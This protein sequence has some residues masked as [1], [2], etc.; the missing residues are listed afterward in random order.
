MKEVR[1]MPNMAIFRMAPLT[2][3]SRGKGSLGKA[4]KHLD[5][6]DRAAEISR[7]DLSS[8]NKNFM[9]EKLSFAECKQLGE[10]LKNKHNKAVDLWNETHDKPKK[11]HLKEDAYQF[12]E[13]VCSYSPNAE[14]NLSEWSYKTL[15]F[16]KD[17]LAAR[18]CRIVRCELHMDENS[19]HIHFIAA[20]Y[21][22]AK[23]N[24]TF[25]N[26]ANGNKGL[27]EWQDK[28]AEA[29]AD[30]GLRRGF[31]RYREFDSIRKK[32]AAALGIEK[33]DLRTVQEFAKKNGFELPKYRGH[34]TIGVWKAEQNEKGIQAEKEVAAIQKEIENDKEVLA[35][36]TADIMTAEGEKSDLIRQ[37]TA[38]ENDIKRQQYMLD[39]IADSVL[40]DDFAERMDYD[41]DR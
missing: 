5:K 12:F 31:S 20:A 18:G 21:D 14:V 2:T 6:H 8:Q 4:L 25:R 40:D 38:I 9:R 29:V 37:K 23:E 11:R 39:H 28:Y 36:L 24:C 30:L 13:G 7:P 35:S 33:P 19:P 16:L 34:K 1:Y 41:L 17:N 22:N 3:K 26:I 10:E 27:C 15:Q 32:C